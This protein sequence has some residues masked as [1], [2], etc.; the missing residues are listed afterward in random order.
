MIILKKFKDKE[1]Q[2]QWVAKSIVKNIKEEELLFKD[3]IVINPIAL[4][5]K[6][7]S[8][9]H[10]EKVIRGGDKQPYSW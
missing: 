5:T 8:F 4:I 1:K 10:K 9:D 7:G 6:K 3:I 2:A